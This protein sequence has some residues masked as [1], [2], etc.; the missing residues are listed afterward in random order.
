VVAFGK[1]HEIARVTLTNAAD[2]RQPRRYSQATT[3]RQG[4]DTGVD[5]VREPSPKCTS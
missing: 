3:S 2:A 1:Q 4:H 5:V